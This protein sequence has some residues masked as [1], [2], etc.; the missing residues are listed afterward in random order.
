M[1]C[2][3]LPS[4]FN[5]GPSRLALLALLVPLTLE[6]LHYFALDSEYTGKYP[7]RQHWSRVAYLTCDAKSD[8]IL[9]FP[10]YAGT[11]A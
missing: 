3:G 10:V 6:A 8:F 11:G 2:A 4:L 5:L 7:Q 9:G 1:P